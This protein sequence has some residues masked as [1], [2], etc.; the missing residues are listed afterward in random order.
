MTS[1]A[2]QLDATRALVDQWRQGDTAARDVLLLMLFGLGTLV[3]VFLIS[4]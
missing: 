3:F 1:T 4:R 2:E